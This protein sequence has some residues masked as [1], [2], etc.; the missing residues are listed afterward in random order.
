MSNATEIK[1]KEKKKNKEEKDTKRFMSSDRSLRIVLYLGRMN[2]LFMMGYKERE[3][4]Q[5]HEHELNYRSTNGRKII[6]SD[7]EERMFLK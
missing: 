6:F 1:K 5:S 7:L 3:N 4:I 2:H